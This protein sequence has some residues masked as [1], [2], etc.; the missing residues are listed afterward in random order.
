[1]LKQNLKN[2]SYQ[3]IAQIIPRA[4]M[5]IF[6]FYLAGALG[7]TEFGKFE[8]ALSLGYLVGMFFELGGNIILTKHVARS[9]YS[10]IYYAVK[11][12]L[13]CILITIALFFTVLFSFGIY[14]ESRTYIIY[15][16]IGL[17][18]SSMMNLY[19]AFF[20]GARKMKYEAAVL[21][22]QKA[23]FIII[24]LVL[25]YSDKSGARVLLAFMMSMIAG[26]LLIF[27][28]FKRKEQEYLKSDDKKEIKF[29]E[30][31]YDVFSLALVEVFSNLYYRLNQVFIEHFKGFEEVG[32]YGAAYRIV[33]VFINFPS[34]LLLAIF[35]AFAKLAV[36]NVKEFRM[37]F[38]IIL[39]LLLFF[40]FLSGLLCWFFG[41]NI[42][43]L[44]GSSYAKSY[45]ILQYLTIPLLF[46]FPNFLVTQ[47]LIALNKNAVFVWILLIALIL[48]IIISLL[49]VPSM[50]AQ[51]SALSI[52]ICEFFIFITGFYY[53]RKF[54]SVG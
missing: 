2:I 46:L 52:G 53:I 4:M 6:L 49:L 30:Y 10:S 23:L 47:G 44:I 40:G 15:A 38:N 18:F 21:L 20:R 42:F 43:M 41:E 8:F 48:N 12:R 14:E 32:I 7:N 17:A 45:S 27:L 36:E 26:F 24:A 5:F 13:V 3:S 33:E 37:Q 16:S 50:G 29:K 9:F 25:I 34:I 31:F 1:M 35:P 11:I 39:G 51:G 54:T 28:I 19:F 22:T